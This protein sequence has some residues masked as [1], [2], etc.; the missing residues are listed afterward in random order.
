MSIETTGAVVS[1]IAAIIS[2]FCALWSFF[3]ERR[4]NKELKAD[5]KL[6][7]G[8]A[9]NPPN[10]QDSHHRDCVIQIPV[11]NISTAKRAFI[12]KVQA[13]RDNKNEEEITW[14][15]AVDHLGSP[16]GLGE[17]VKVNESADLYLRV[18]SGESVD[19]LTIKI[20]H[21]FSTAA[22]VVVFNRFE[23]LV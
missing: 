3:N 22:S 15:A 12:T 13:Y 11:H 8:K 6:I 23:G 10:I 5:E 16:Q 21:S 19:F 4:I 9:H 18:N 14:S 1:I 7:F 2:G 17:V 20:F